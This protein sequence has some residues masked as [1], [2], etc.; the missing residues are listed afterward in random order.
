MDPRCAS[1]VPVVSRWTVQGSRTSRRGPRLATA[2]LATAR[3]AT[4]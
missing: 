4:A 3:L 1:N 2:R